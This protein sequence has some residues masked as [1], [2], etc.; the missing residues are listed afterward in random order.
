LALAIGFVKDAVA[1]GTNGG[2]GQSEHEKIV[3]K[4]RDEIMMG[5][6]L[7]RIMI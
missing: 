7:N 6:S 1:K 4:Q 5:I 2:F 3:L